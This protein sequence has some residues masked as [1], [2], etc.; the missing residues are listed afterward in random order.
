M[1]SRL[2]AVVA[3]LLI[4]AGIAAFLVAAGWIPWTYPVV[5]FA[6]VLLAWGFVAVRRTPRPAQPITARGGRPGPELWD[7]AGR[8]LDD[9]SGRG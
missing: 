5:L 8:A 9:D 2:F 7:P 4:V 3:L 6:L 1:A